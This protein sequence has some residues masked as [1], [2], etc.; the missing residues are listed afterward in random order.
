MKISIITPSF[1]QAGFIRRTIE[2]V[3]SQ[4]GRAVSPKRER[5]ST[6]DTTTSGNTSA[7]AL[8]ELEHIIVD[9]G[10]TDGT[11]DILKSY[12]QAI[13][14]ISEKDEGQADAL[15]KGLAMAT[16][17]VIGWVNS[18]DLYE[19]G[20]LA[21]VARVFESE[22]QTQWVYGKVR[23][24]DAQDRE[25]RRWITRYKN[26]R[27]RRYSFPK[28][29]AE[30]WISQMGVFWRASAGREVGAFRKDLHYCMDYNFWLRLGQRWPG[31]FIDQ[32]LAAFRWYPS[33]KS[34]AGFRKQFAEEYAVAQ[35]IAAGKYP[36]AMFRH[37]MNF[38]RI[39]AAYTMM[40]W[41][42]K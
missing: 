21:T 17:D 15:N 29:L 30:N 20:C 13:R 27:M 9:G 22:P 1:N 16:G 41:L 12:G 39:V 4:A 31:R 25:I 14:W 40:K 28:L 33:S 38:A 24:V 5:G 34:G 2:S 8:F 18:D 26:L 32:Y 7:R 3:E 6:R 23:I 37:R 42:G 11:V 36:F 35:E 10:S 19:P